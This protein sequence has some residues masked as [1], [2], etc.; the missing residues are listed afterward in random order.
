MSGLTSLLSVAKLGLLTQQINL[1]TT[2]HNIANVTTDGYSRQ[3]VSLAS[4]TPSPSEIGPI[5]TG[6]QATQ[7]TRDYDRF[8]NNTLFD[9]ISIM[10]GLDTLQAGMKLV[11]GVFNEVDENGL[12]RILNDFWNAWDDIA[13]NAESADGTAERTMLLQRASLL[14]QRVRDRYNSMVKLSHDIDLNIQTAVDDINQ[15][16]DQVAEINV[17][18]LSLESGGHQANDLRDQRDELVRQLDELTGINCFETQRG[19]YTVLIGQGSPLVE[20]NRSWHLGFRSG[21]V[22]WLGAG[23][24]TAEL[25]SEDIVSGELGGLINLKE[26]ITP[27]DTRVLTGAVAN[28]TGG[29]P[30]KAKAAWADMDGVT[31]SGPFTIDFSGTDQQGF[32]VTGTYDSTVDYNGDGT[33][34]T[35]S[36]F[37]NTIETAFGGTVEAAIDSTGRLVLT[38]T[39]PGDFPISFQIEGTSGGVTGLN[40]GTFGTYPVNYMEE[41][42]RWAQAL[43]KAV[44]SQHTQGAGLVPFQEVVA[45][46]TVTNP[47]QPI[48][49]RSSGLEFAAEVQDGEFEIWLYDAAGDV[50]DL[51]PAGS[52]LVNDPLRITITEGVTTLSDIADAINAD[53][54]LGIGASTPGGRLVISV[55]GSNPEVAGFAFA[56]DT[57]GAL[58]A[59]GLNTFFTGHDASTIDINHY[60]T[61]DPRLIAAA[62]AASSGS[63]V[64]TSANAVRD[65][66]RPLDSTVQS[67]TLTVRLY[68]DSSLLDTE[69]TITINAGTTSLERVVEALNDI[70]GIDA[71]ID[72][73]R[74][75]IATSQT[76]WTI[77]LDDGT[78][79]FLDYFWEAP[80]SFPAESIESDYVADRTFQPFSSF[81]TGIHDGT[82][83]IGLVSSAGITNVAIPLTIGSLEDVAGQID[84]V[85]GLTAEVV[86]GRLRIKV[87]EDYDA[88]VFVNDDTGLLEYM[89]L[90]TPSGGELDPANNLNAL[91]IHDIGR[92]AVDTLQG[93]TLYE[94][95]NSLVG[96]IGLH[97]RGFQLDYEFSRATVNEIRARRDEIAGVSL[98]EEMANLI[99]FQQAYTAAAKLINVADEM[100]ITLLEIKR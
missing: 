6:V 70:E 41:L 29:Q 75:R 76:G 97:S 96:S 94:A 64:V 53:P 46:N 78:T 13:N 82:L 45:A 86:D 33:A 1:Q 77:A 39:A 98:D 68:D 62:Q 47:T 7:I 35:V 15:I 14:V 36:D 38:N 27:R 30:L 66:E 3:N 43:I 48:S 69:Q 61:G 56:S 31:V 42:T 52:P 19:T 40:F 73:G 79:Q 26:R 32:P 8:V 55:N 4:T 74:L 44:N 51:D 49:L 12:N 60:V 10:S 63:A 59:L 85:D 99:K 22:T 11:E 81:D 100:F 25:T 37:L 58:S 71:E 57:S 80:P 92:T 34:G 54:G 23:G 2:G 88:L 20:G 18:I 91:A 84:Q 5:G 9:R 89:G 93:S 50:I 87:E 16:V 67:G 83:E 24:Q 95:Y 90:S 72:E 28:T 21:A 17:Q 65:P